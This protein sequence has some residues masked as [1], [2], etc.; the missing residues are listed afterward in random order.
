[1]TLALPTESLSPVPDPSLCS[2]SNG[3]RL[4]MESCLPVAWDSI[5]SRLQSR[6]SDS[7][8]QSSN[9]S[10]QGRLCHRFANF[11]P[12]R[13][14]NGSGWN[15]KL[16]HLLMELTQGLQRGHGGQVVDFQFAEFFDHGVIFRDE[17]L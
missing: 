2:G 14:A 17:E 4:G 9:A 6:P 12:T 11:V 5:P 1:M 13:T 8:P 7:I 15:P 3:E 16:L 10:V